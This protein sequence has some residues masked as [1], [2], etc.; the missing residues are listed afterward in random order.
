MLMTNTGGKSIKKHISVYST[1][2]I[3]VVLGVA[4]KLKHR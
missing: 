3:V 1:G 4:F 2:N